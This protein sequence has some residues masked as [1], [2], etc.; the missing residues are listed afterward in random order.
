MDWFDP[1]SGLLLLDEHLAERPSF[2]NVL[3]DGVV[4]DG[5]LAEQSARVVGLLKNLEQRLPTELKDLTG[6]CLVELAVLHALQHKH[7]R[8]DC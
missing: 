8:Q 1:E 7:A 2:R 3:A 4:T 6:E 5:E